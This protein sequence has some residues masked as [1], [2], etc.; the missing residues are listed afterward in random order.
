VFD[1]R[2]TTLTVYN[3]IVKEI[4]ASSMRG[5][6]GTIFAYGQTSSGK[7]HTMYGSGTELGIIKLAVRNMF[8]IADNDPSRE[9]LIR[10]SFLEIYNEILRDLLEPSKTNLKIH[11]N[12]KREIYVGDLTQQVVSNADEVEIIL[13]KGDRNRQVAGTNMNER[14][15]RSHTIFSI[16]VESREAADPATASA[17]DSDGRDSGIHL[18]GSQRLSTGSGFGSG[19]FAG[20]VMVSSLNLV[21]L[22]GSERVGQTG[23]E[24]QRLKEGSHINKSLHALGNVIVRLADDGGDRGHIP[25]RDSKLTR[26]LQPSLGGNAKTLIICT[27]TPSPDYI[28][29][30][31]ST[32]KFASR[33][34][35]IQNKPEVNEEVRGNTLLWRIER[36]SKLELERKM[37]DV[38]RKMAEAEHEKKELEDQRETLMRKMWKMQKE[39]KALELS[40]SK[41]A[42]DNASTGPAGEARRQTWHV[43]PLRTLSDDTPALN[44]TSLSHSADGIGG[45]AIA[46]DVDEDHIDEAVTVRSR[47]RAG[48]NGNSDHPADDRTRDLELQ[49][50]SLELQNT[51]MQT[52]CDEA[53]KRTQDMNRE[54]ER[55][56]RDYTMLLSELGQLA[57]A[58]DIPPSPAKNALSTEPREV[59]D[60]RRRVRELLAALS[61]S[62]KHVIKIRSQRSEAEFLEM[63]KQ[64]TQ[65]ALTQRETELSASQ[66]QVEELRNQL[67]KTLKSLDLAEESR[68]G[69]EKQLAEAVDAKTEAQ[70]ECRSTRAKMEQERLG[71]TSALRSHKE[72]AAA[73][74]SRLETA[75]AALQARL[76]EH[77]QQLAKG[78]GER[79]RARAALDKAEADMADKQGEVDALSRDLG[80]SRQK[81]SELELAL[82]ENTAAL[83]TARGAYLE[84]K[85]KAQEAEA[86]K[87]KAVAGSAELSEA[88]KQLESELAN[89]DTAV[90]ELRKQVGSLEAAAIEAA[91]DRLSLQ[92]KVDHYSQVVSDLKAGAR[93]SIDAAQHE[94]DGLRQELE[95][96]VAELDTKT[97][98]INSLR[99]ELEA[100]QL[101]GA[102]AASTRQKLRDAEE[103]LTL[104]NGELDSARAALDEL[105]AMSA[106]DKE[107]LR[108]SV[109]D[110]RNTMEHISALTTQFEKSEHEHASM[111]AERDSRLAM[112][113]G[114]EDKA[115]ER[116][117]QLKEQLASAE[118]RLSSTQA[119]LVQKQAR[120]DAEVSHKAE[121]LRQVE[122]NAATMQEQQAD[123]AR[124]Q[125]DVDDKARMLSESECQNNLL[126]RK[127]DGDIAAAKARYFELQEGLDRAALTYREDTAKLEAQVQDEQ[128]RVS[129]LQQA[130][131]DGEHAEA[132][133]RQQ[134]DMAAAANEKASKEL[135]EL[136]DHAT[137]VLA[138]YSQALS[139]AN[140]MQARAETAE[141]ATEE[142]RQ[143]LQAQVD[144]LRAQ[145]SQTHD[146]IARLQQ[147]CDVLTGDVRR[148]KDLAESSAASAD[149]SQKMLVD[150]ENS[151]GTRITAL[152][153]QL[154]AVTAERDG[155]KQEAADKNAQLGDT[156]SE[157]DKLRSELDALRL[158]RTSL[159]EKHAN[160]S[161][162]T[163]SLSA[164]VESANAK[165]N[166]ALAQCDEQ[167]DR[168][169][170][171]AAELKDLQSTS[172]GCASEL[173]TVSKAHDAL[174]SRAADLKQALDRKVAECARLST[175]IGDE[176]EMRHA[177]TERLDA[178]QVELKAAT[179]T[180]KQLRHRIGVLEADLRKQHDAQSQLRESI[181][182]IQ[183]G[184]ASANKVAAERIESLE[185][186][187][188]GLRCQLF[189]THTK[190]DTLEKELEG[191]RAAVNG[192]LLANG[193][194]SN[195]SQKLRANYEALV[196]GSKSRQVDLEQAIADLR[197]AMDGRSDEIRDLEDALASA[198]AD[199][200]AA[201]T[202]VDGKHQ[203][204]RDL[205]AALKVANSNLEAAKTDVSDATRSSIEELE[206]QVAASESRAAELEATIGT[207]RAEIERRAELEESA[208][209]EHTSLAEATAAIERL[210]EERDQ[211]YQSIDTLKAMMTE[212]ADI[213]DAEYAEIE[214]K[215]AQQTERLQITTNEL[216]E[217][218]ELVKQLEGRAT[219]HLSRAVA[220]EADMDKALV[221]N[222]LEIKNLT[223][224]RDGMEA[225]LGEVLL[226]WE[227]LEAR[228]KESTAKGDRLE[229]EIERHKIAMADLQERLD[230]ATAS[231]ADADAGTTAAKQEL[232]DLVSSVSAELV[233]VAKS[234]SA[235]P[236]CA[237]VVDTESTSYQVL[238]AAIKEMAAIASTRTEASDSAP[239]DGDIARLQ[240]LNE[241]LEKKVA[242][243]RDVYT[244]DMTKLHADEEKHC[245]QAESLAKELAN[246]VLLKEAA[247]AEL[248]RIRGDLEAQCRRRMELEAMV[249]QQE[250]AHHGSPTAKPKARLASQRTPTAHEN[251]RAY[252]VSPPDAT[253]SPISLSTL[254]SRMGAPEDQ[255]QK[256]CPP[257]K[258]TALG[259]DA[260][261]N[262]V[263]PA[264]KAESVRARS[265]YGDRHRMRRNQQAPRPVGL[266]EQATEQC[267]QQ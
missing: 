248:A 256:P 172:E 122:A 100:S 184:H 44:R 82:V 144:D 235:L 9:Y 129:E 229:S 205:E 117:D 48:L 254:N 111:L 70:R 73:T 46:M 59:A 63:E 69:C 79:Q 150:A 249:A 251:R 169:E 204:I 206:S 209:S 6:N 232:R 131:A 88:A 84:A 11:E 168:A 196:Y 223:A 118:A 228:V 200:E 222:S 106:L 136:K 121:L 183:A 207:M 77:R 165:C 19:E 145:N 85:V 237:Q 198:N 127:V 134:L 66:L 114:L 78:E 61:E 109:D 104:R 33:A 208:S 90:S 133:L 178:I 166:E 89:A 221:Q 177:S 75:N 231:L 99:Q 162:L 147:A 170:S 154:D 211:A 217:K 261:A 125:S 218:D 193:V 28:E 135:Q 93:A 56:T 49:N 187:H 161:S 182:D 180:E 91:V 15:S 138:D 64:A 102:D 97:A 81:V 227:Q 140:Q 87:A 195:E 137:K 50:K 186:D 246:T 38:E 65:E 142:T 213:K 130:I 47:G 242:K 103:A 194:L 244:A 267:V 80:A 67:F 255:P 123:L 189:A 263:E 176:I 14:S 83:S 27:I 71:L 21:D 86:E 7:T 250:S 226:A 40:V 119:E 238:L 265:S 240:A 179:T 13:R 107:K 108:K 252:L 158:E 163:L 74:E 233:A 148:H 149:Q 92:T 35:T 52:K 258:R 25:Y 58:A 1:Q 197:S 181:S 42:S 45:L 98:D 219:E 62:R 139:N 234:L 68:L 26:I 157:H 153:A 128:N 51:D 151:A 152:Q 171:Y 29:E 32:L 247:D 216:S 230:Q 22:A 160:L 167:R 188:V 23:A 241:K 199:L 159:L 96:R 4:V 141:R 3:D 36:D 260:C 164:S 116:A 31:V 105:N 236:G 173:A 10:V 220:A 110:F 175:Q 34:K 174:E 191:S 57:K 264:A 8:D 115:V 243:L 143:E 101:A 95:A 126:V 113:Q 24:G 30:A 43:G 262:G 2:D 215:L 18:N 210:S 37:V 12:T 54:L 239:S 5:F 224:E 257:R 124:L 20:A 225:K 120:L 76:E 55:I 155:L 94:I 16:I 39:Y 201:K 212:L 202:E 146:E 253:L 53:S 72:K 245:Q 214:E 203:K 156:A 185:A 192:A 41:A 60:M 190:C 259:P 132:E 112:L 17:S 266:E